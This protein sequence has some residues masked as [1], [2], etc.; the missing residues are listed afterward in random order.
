[1]MMRGGR[2]AVVVEEEAVICTGLSVARIVAIR[3]F[4]VNK[5][6]QSVGPHQLRT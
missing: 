4:V 2:S 6:E 5:G 3:P 1:M